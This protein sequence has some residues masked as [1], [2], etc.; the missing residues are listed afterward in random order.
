MFSPRLSRQQQARKEE[1]ASETQAT[2]LGR[3]CPRSLLKSVCPLLCLSSC[4]QSD[5]SLN[6]RNASDG[7]GRAWAERPLLLWEINPSGCRGSFLQIQNKEIK[8]NVITCMG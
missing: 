4:S 1:P 3:L 7:L 6:P 2:E 8:E 5:L